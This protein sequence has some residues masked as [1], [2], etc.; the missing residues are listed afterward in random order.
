MKDTLIVNAISTPEVVINP[1]IIYL[2]GVFIG[3]LIRKILISLDRIDIDNEELI[4][5]GFMIIFWPVFLMCLIIVVTYFLIDWL[6]CTLGSII[7]SLLKRMF[8]GL[9]K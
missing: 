4:V 3:W 7:A 5:V 6:M 8:K 9:N 1:L 2:L